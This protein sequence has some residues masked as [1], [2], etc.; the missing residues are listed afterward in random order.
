MRDLFRNLRSTSSY[1]VLA[2][3]PSKPD[4]GE[5]ERE[6][7]RELKTLKKGWR[8]GSGSGIFL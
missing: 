6:G 2:C 1:A 7:E 3:S 4:E 8:G 5:G